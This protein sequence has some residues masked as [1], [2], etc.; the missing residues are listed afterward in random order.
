MTTEVAKYKPLENVLQNI[1]KNYISISQA[2]RNANNAILK[3]V[4]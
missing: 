3:E 4:Q 1:N 2:D